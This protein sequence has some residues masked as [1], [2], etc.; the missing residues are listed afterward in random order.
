MVGGPDTGYGTVQWIIAAY[1]WSIG[2]TTTVAI[3]AA[4]V[5]PQVYFQSTL[6]FPDPE[7]NDIRYVTMSQPSS[8]LSLFVAAMTIGQHEWQ[9][10]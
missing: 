3:L 6:L 8:V 4:L 2:E 9:V 5:L 1:F 7:A 10:L